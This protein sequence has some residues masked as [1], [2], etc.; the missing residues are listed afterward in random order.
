MKDK[1]LFLFLKIKTI[2]ILKI[3]YFV[4]KLNSEILFNLQGKTF[5]QMEYIQF[6]DLRKLSLDYTGLVSR[7]LRRINYT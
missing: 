7:L 6:E 4:L 3:T 2:R 5:D 1:R